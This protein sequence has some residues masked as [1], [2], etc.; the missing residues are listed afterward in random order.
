MQKNFWENFQ[1]AFSTF[2]KSFWAILGTYFS[3]ILVLGIF[4]AIVALTLG[5]DLAMLLGSLYMDPSV[6][7]SNMLPQLLIFLSLLVV[8]FVLFYFIGL[9]IF[10]IIKNNAVVGRSLM[11]ES[12]KEALRKMWKVLLWSIIICVCFVLGS[13]F[14]IL[15]LRRFAVILIFPLTLLSLPFVFAGS[16]GMM[17]QEGG[18]GK[19]LSESISLGGKKWGNILITY[20]LYIL[21]AVVFLVVTGGI[22]V[23]ITKYG[24]LTIGKIFGAIVSFLFQAF[25]YCFF[26]VYYLNIAEMLPQN[27]TVKEISQEELIQNN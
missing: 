14:S 10:I 15:L 2:R 21:L 1:Y 8:L 12:F 4:A 9:W 13:T 17:Y 7:A 25:S 27:E 19:I 24:L 16:F 18:F 23:V 22:Q 26:T 11:I 6:A 3:L 5:K 20:I